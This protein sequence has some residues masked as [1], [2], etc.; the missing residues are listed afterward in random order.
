MTLNEARGL[1]AFSVRYTDHVGR[2][3]TTWAYG[4]SGK[5]KDSG[6]SWSL[7]TAAEAVSAS[8]A[9]LDLQADMA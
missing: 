7:G 4:W 5:V 6:T 9:P 8:L 1:P 3:M 2:K